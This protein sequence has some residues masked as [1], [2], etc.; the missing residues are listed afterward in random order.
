MLPITILILTARWQAGTAEKDPSTARTILYR[1]DT[2]HEGTRIGGVT[3]MSEG[4]ETE[5]NY[6]D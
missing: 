4:C 1:S 3:G 6:N 5:E 2:M